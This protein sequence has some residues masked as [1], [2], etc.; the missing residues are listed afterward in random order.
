MSISNNAVRQARQNID[1]VIEQSYDVFSGRLSH[2]SFN[3]Q[4]AKSST[5]T[6]TESEIWNV[7]GIETLLTSPEVI[8]ISS[9]S[10][11]DTAA[12]TGARTLRIEGLD[13]NYDLQ[14]EI[15][16][17][18]G[19]TPVNTVNTYLRVHRLTAISAG[20]TG[21][22]QGNIDAV[23]AITMA[24]HARITALLGRSEK[25]QFTCPRNHI[26]P[27]TDVK[28]GVERNDEAE[29]RFYLRPF[30][31]I[32]TLRDGFK[33]FENTVVYSLKIPFPI[34]PRADISL[35]AV[36]TGAGSTII[37]FEYKFYLIKT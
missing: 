22:N 25:T 26:M 19:V 37:T 12:G 11:N 32:F 4:Y 23:S 36:N 35:R 5:I 30:G 9:S 20:S 34:P 33:I 3:N 13:G 27:V 21:I 1:Y 10:A 2:Y 24:T 16:V 14:S 6:A 7:G 31:E 29:W 15:V 17:L 18:N 28:A 8:Q